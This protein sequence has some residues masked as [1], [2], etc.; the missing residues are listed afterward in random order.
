MWV[1]LYCHQFPPFLVRRASGGSQQ[2]ISIAVAISQPI[3]TGP[4]IS[5]WMCSTNEA[6]GNAC[7]RSSI[8]CV[9]NHRKISEFALLFSCS[10]VRFYFAYW[11]RMRNKCCLELRLAMGPLL[12]Y[13]AIG[14]SLEKAS[15]DWLRLFMCIV[16]PKSLT[17]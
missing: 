9:S 13:Q 5:S 17:S 11:I 15:S 4:H 10:H 16:I 8:S 12:W 2:L 3:C 7:Y 6:I 1:N 14:N